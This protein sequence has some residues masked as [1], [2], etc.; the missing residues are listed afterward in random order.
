M[1][2]T[3]RVGWLWRPAFAAASAL[4]LFLLGCAGPLLL[5]TNLALED[6]WSSDL[7]TTEPHRI[8]IGTDNGAAFLGSGWHYGE[9]E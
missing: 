6:T 8:D 5:E 4:L 7:Q 3:V 9:T 1:R 2:G